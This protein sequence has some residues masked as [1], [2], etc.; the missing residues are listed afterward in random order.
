MAVRARQVVPAL[1]V[2]LVLFASQA[3]YA[4]R[5]YER[6]NGHCAG[7]APPETPCQLPLWLPCC[8]D[9]AAVSAGTVV[10]PPAPGLALALEAAHAPALALSIAASE[11]GAALPPATP[12]RLGVLLQI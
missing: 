7:S 12:L 8:D 9:Q 6:P 1:L 10:L 11:S 4:A 3:A 2:L 5:A